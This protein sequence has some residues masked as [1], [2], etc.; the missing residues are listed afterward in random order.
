MFQHMFE[1]FARSKRFVALLTSVLPLKIVISHVITETG[2]GCECFVA[3]VTVQYLLIVRSQMVTQSG[4]IS[5]CFPALCTLKKG[6][7]PLC[8][9]KCSFK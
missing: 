4:V 1:Y 7:S 6:F 3:L 5:E 8:V 9:L 2:F